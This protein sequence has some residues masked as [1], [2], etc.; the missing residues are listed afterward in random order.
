M[1]EFR[2]AVFVAEPDTKYPRTKSDMAEF[3]CAVFVAEMN[4]MSGEAGSL[5]YP[6][7]TDRG[8][9]RE[10]NVTASRYGPARERK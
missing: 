2:S 7:R 8:G 6:L 1:A 5:K 4:K 10:G 9:R 3:R